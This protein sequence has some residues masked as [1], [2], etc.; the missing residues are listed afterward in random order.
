MYP[1]CNHRFPGPLAPS[2]NRLHKS[3]PSDLSYMKRRH[4]LEWYRFRNHWTPDWR[5]RRDRVHSLELVVTGTIG[6][7]STP[8]VDPL[9]GRFMGNPPFVELTDRG[10][11]PTKVLVELTSDTGHDLFE[12]S[13]FVLQ[14]LHRIMEN[15]DCGVLLPNHLTKVATLTKS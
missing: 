5:R 4:H 6:P 10:R 12:A 15:I 9:D 13:Q 1:A 8:L 7:T 14:V 2:V 3:R 11:T